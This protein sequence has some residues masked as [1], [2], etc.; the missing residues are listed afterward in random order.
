[1]ELNL[2]AYLG[3]G[4]LTLINAAP[5]NLLGTFGSVSFLGSRTATVNYS[6][7]TG[8]V[9]LTNFSGGGGSLAVNAVPEPSSAAMIAVAGFI[10]LSFGAGAHRQRASSRGMQCLPIRA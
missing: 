10:L 7:A 4:P 9:T 2:D 5:G 1:L 6:V 3:A 8:D